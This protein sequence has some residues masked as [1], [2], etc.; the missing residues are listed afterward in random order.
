MGNESF[1]PKDVE[2]NKGTQDYQSMEGKKQLIDDT[3]FMACPKC[4]NGK[5]RI[6]VSRYGSFFVACTAFPSCKHT[7]FNLP[8]KGII[9][10]KVSK[11]ECE[12]CS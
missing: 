10:A 3:E 5:L 6:K 1:D 12:S 9:S 4:K 7:Q 2:S 8:K 11:T